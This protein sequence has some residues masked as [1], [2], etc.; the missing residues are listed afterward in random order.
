MLRQFLRDDKGAVVIW[1]FGCNHQAFRDSARRGLDSALDVVAGLKALRIEQ[2]HAGSRGRSSVSSSYAATLRP[3]VG[4]TS[5]TAYCGVVGS[6]YRCEYAVL[7]PAVNLAAR[8]MCMCHKK[9]VELL[10]NDALKE[11]LFKQQQQT[12]DESADEYAFAPFPAMAVK[13]YNE[14]VVFYHATPVSG[15]ATA[16][17]RN[18]PPSEWLNVDLQQRM[19]RSSRASVGPDDVNLSAALDPDGGDHASYYL[20]ADDPVNPMTTPRKNGGVALTLVRW[21]G[22]GRGRKGSAE[23]GSGD[24]TSQSRSAEASRRLRLQVLAA[25]QFSASLPSASSL[26]SDLPSAGRA[27]EGTIDGGG[28]LARFSKERRQSA[29]RARFGQSGANEVGGG[30]EMEAMV[31]SM[32]DSLSLRDQMVLKVSSAIALVGTTSDHLHNAAASH[33]GREGLRR[34]S[35]V[36]DNPEFPRSVLINTFPGSAKV[37]D[38]AILTSLREF[39]VRVGD[40]DHSKANNSRRRSSQ[41][42]AAQAATTPSDVPANEESLSEAGDSAAIVALLEEDGDDIIE[43]LSPADNDDV[44]DADSNAYDE[45]N[46]D[47][48]DAFEEDMRSRDGDAAAASSSSSSSSSSSRQHKEVVYQ[49]RSGH[50][51]DIVYNLMLRAQRQRIHGQIAAWY[52]RVRGLQQQQRSMTSHYQQQLDDKKSSSNSS[53]SHHSSYSLQRDLIGPLAFHYL[54][55]GEL[56][57]AKEH[58]I[59]AGRVAVDRADYD[60]A[61]AHFHECLALCD[62]VDPNDSS[63]SSSSS[64][65]NNKK[66]IGGAAASFSNAASGSNRSNNTSSSGGWDARKGDKSQKILV[67]TPRSRRLRDLEATG[68]ARRFLDDMENGYLCDALFWLAQVQTRYGARLGGSG[69]GGGSKNG[70]FDLDDDALD[71]ISDS[72]S[73]DEEDE[74]GVSG[75]SYSLLEVARFS[76]DVR[77]KALLKRAL[78]LQSIRLMHRVIARLRTSTI[79]V[80]FGHWRMEAF[81]HSDDHEN[82][83]DLHPVPVFHRTASSRRRSSASRGKS[84]S[85]VSGGG[86]G[87][88]GGIVAVRREKTA[89]RSSLPGRVKGKPERQQQQNNTSIT[90]TALAS[91]H[92]NNRRTARLRAQL[93]W[94][95]V[96]GGTREMLRYGATIER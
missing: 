75:G 59:A 70:D 8:L 91:F 51:A 73:D 62:S 82:S 12:N 38:A 45:D 94:V 76:E 84:L 4:L 42:L 43:G 40:D 86:S 16:I 83:G 68:R 29:A 71:A 85:S 95:L 6:A 93:A 66:S 81:Y 24:V 41:Q 30:V 96:A 55:A 34:I 72:D 23:G 88:G 67:R 87:D 14:P 19:R 26:S 74:D 25:E 5:G 78:V 20:A 61:A 90:P 21:L 56:A 64:G 27:N 22:T 44:D 28:V 49:F 17:A 60:A 79:A 80:Y 57:L 52:E 89:R 63:S 53:N 35:T 92:A 69:L 39:I 9:E 10:V 15:R 46:D 77:P 1:T 7:G 18:R 32:L 50:T 58:L 48:D 13:G 3:V 65:S 37:V 54:K 11:Q 36:L 47:D 33:H 31:L 2:R